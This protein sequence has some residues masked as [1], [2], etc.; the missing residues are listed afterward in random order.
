[1]PYVNGCR[2][3][4]QPTDGSTR[5]A[6]C[7]KLRRLEAAATRAHRRA[8]GLCLTCGAP[9]ARSK[10]TGGAAGKRVRAEARYCR[11][12]LAYYAARQRLAG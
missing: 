11:P 9:V 2:S 8:H 5:C 7:R 6:E 4:G 3:C 1:M 10:L 12:H